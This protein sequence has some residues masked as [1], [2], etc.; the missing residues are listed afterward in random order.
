MFSACVDKAKNIPC[1][2]SFVLSALKGLCFVFHFEEGDNGELL[3]IK[4]FDGRGPFVS[5]TPNQITTNAVGVNIVPALGRQRTPTIEQILECMSIKDFLELK[6]MKRR[7]S[8]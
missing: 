3:G 6:G 1:V 4:G 7:K 8:K 2:L 5:L